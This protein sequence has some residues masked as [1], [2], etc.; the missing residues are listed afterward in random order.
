[1]AQCHACRSKALF[2][3]VLPVHVFHVMAFRTTALRRLC[4]LWSTFAIHFAFLFAD[5]PIALFLNFINYFWTVTG[6]NFFVHDLPSCTATKDIHRCF[7]CRRRT[8]VCS[9]NGRRPGCGTA[10]LTVDA[11]SFLR[12][13]VA[14]EGPIKF[15]PIDS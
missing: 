8:S 5:L 3:N 13:T 12:W 6:N 15:A 1:M 9:S 11:A 2:S 7:T 14:G 4:L 10:V